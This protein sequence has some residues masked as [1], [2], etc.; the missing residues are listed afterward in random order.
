MKKT[1]FS[2]PSIFRRPASGISLAGRWTAPLLR[3]RGFTLVEMLVVIA[4][5][6]I[7]VAI[8]IPNFGALNDS[9]NVLGAAQTI[10]T[11][12]QLAKMRAISQSKRSRILFLSD[13]SYKFQYYDS[14]GS[15]WKD[16]SGETV[17]TFDTCSNPYFHEGVTIT[18]PAGN[19]VVFQPWG[20]SSS[21]SIQV[22]NAH[23]RG[24]ITVSNTGKISTEVIDL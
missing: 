10:A 5:L 21:A 3:R 12:L 18:G 22:Q 13:T 15:I 16:L 2:C 14:A 4:L 8:A 1:T 20:S 24:T 11:D 6:G 7:I 9:A 23:K 19:E 17:R